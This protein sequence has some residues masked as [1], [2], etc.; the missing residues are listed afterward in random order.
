MNELEIARKEINEIDE[1][2]AKLF[3]ARMKVCARVAHYKQSHG[4]SIRDR[5]RENDLINKNRAFIGDPDINS[6]YV[7]FIRNT[8]DLSCAYQLRLMKG[9]RVICCSGAEDAAHAMFPEAGLSVRADIEEAYRAVEEGKS[10]IAVLPLEGEN[11]SVSAK[12]LFTGEL[13]VNQ[14][15]DVKTENGTV[16]CGAFSGARS[17]PVSARKRDGEGF[18]LVFTVRNETGALAQ[19]LNI[20]GAHGYNMRSLRSC[21]KEDLPW[22]S[23]FY[24]EAEGSIEGENGKELL[25]ELSAVCAKLKLAGSFYTD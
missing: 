9:L 14:I 5:E 2:M 10:D 11:A 18:I 6:Y 25:Q 17:M 24:L 3:E 8:I 16:R 19:V 13:Y 1:Q 23:F 21:P 15:Y 20:I 4:L 12:L 7:R 22:G